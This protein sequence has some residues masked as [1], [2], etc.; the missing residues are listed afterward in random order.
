MLKCFRSVAG[1]V[2]AL[3]ARGA[4]SGCST[5]VQPRNVDD[6]LNDSLEEADLRGGMLEGGES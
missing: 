6:L 2:L 3:M 5:T 1:A 4:F